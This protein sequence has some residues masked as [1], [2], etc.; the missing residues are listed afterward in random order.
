MR[1]KSILAFCLV[2][3]LVAAMLGGCAAPAPMEPTPEPTV[4]P[5]AAPTE[6]PTPEPTAEPVELMVF[7]AASMTESLAKIAEMYKEVAPN[8]TLVFNF[9]SSGTLKTQIQEGAEADIFISAGQLQMNQLDITAAADV[10][11]DGLDFV[12]SPTR[13]NLVTNTVV[14]IV[15]NGSDKGIASFDDIATDKVSLI[16][17]G[18]A[19]VPVGQY[20]QDVFT[21]LG[22]WD[23]LNADKKVSFGTNVKEVLTQV[24]TGAVDCG[25]VYISDAATSSGVTVVASAPEGSHKPVNYPAAVLK[26]TKNPEA[27]AAFLDF[28][29]TDACSAV[30]TGIGFG[31]PTR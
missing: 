13:F 19:D 25:V 27:A 12:D 8:V 29:K 22:V 16:A 2:C 5:T 20:A 7:A 10:N 6:A 14:L 4:A 15:P 28:L 1:K 17:L 24:E 11:T 26:A 31:I 23:K 3:A 30:F 9:D 21:F 18:N